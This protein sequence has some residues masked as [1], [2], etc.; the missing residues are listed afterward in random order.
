[1]G[2]NKK[3]YHTE[4]IDGAKNVNENN[5]VYN[6]KLRRNI[7]STVKQNIYLEIEKRGLSL[8]DFS[9]MADVSYSNLWTTF[10]GQ[11]H[12]LSMDSLIKFAYALE[13]PI[14]QLFPEEITSIETN[15]DRFDNITKGLD[16]A[17]INFL[18]NFVIN[19][20]NENKRLREKKE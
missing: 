5:P 11:E 3:A 8:A 7:N 18:L 2:R 10:F 14:A 15:G 17:S 1:M 19:Y 6:E 9:V 13:I 12:M 20:V 4:K 16:E